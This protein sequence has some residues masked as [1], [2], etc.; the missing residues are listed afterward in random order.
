MSQPGE[1]R[2]LYDGPPLPNH[3]RHRN[4]SREI[5]IAMAAPGSVAP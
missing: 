4:N 5:E 2:P 3:N 1:V